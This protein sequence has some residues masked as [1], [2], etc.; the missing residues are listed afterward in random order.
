MAEIIERYNNPTKHVEAPYA[1]IHRNGDDYFI[2]VSKDS[3]NPNWLEMGKFLLACFQ[4]SIKSE[5]FIKNCLTTYEILNEK[6][7]ATLFDSEDVL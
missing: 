5:D 7:E 2:Q 1:T 4:N 3:A 6:P